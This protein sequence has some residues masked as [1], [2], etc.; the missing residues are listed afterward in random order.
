MVVYDGTS[1]TYVTSA[2]VTGPATSVAVSGLVNGASYSFDVRASNFSAVY[3]EG[4]SSALSARSVVFVPAK[5]PQ[6]VVTV[7][8]GPRIKSVAGSVVKGRTVATVR[9]AAPSNGGKPILGYRVYAY[10]VDAAGHVLSST[11]TTTISASRRS[12]SMTFSGVS[13]YRFAMRAVNAIGWSA[14]GGLST[15]MAPASAPSAP[16]M[17]R[18]TSGVPGGA[19]TASVTW[20][21]PRSNGGTV[22]TGYR[23]FIYQL[24]A[25]G[26]VLSVTTSSLLKASARSWTGRLPAAGPYAFAVRAVNAMGQSRASAR[27]STVTG[28]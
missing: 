24:S 4:G 20:S 22:V 6:P 3:N 7:P 26:D 11:R 19:V 27:S 15:T 9:W 25:G 21:A 16:R 12:W 13:R 18:A 1:T 17:G 10:K 14:Y 2:H 8:Q 23:V 5:P 28:R